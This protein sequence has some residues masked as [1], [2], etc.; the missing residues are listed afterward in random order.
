MLRANRRFLIA[1]VSLWVL[2]QCLVVTAFHPQEV[3]ID[4]SHMDTLPHLA[5]P[6]NI[7]P[8]TVFRGVMDIFVT[9]PETSVTFQLPEPDTYWVRVKA[10]FLRSNQTLE[11]ALNDTPLVPMVSTQAKRAQKFVW[12]VPPSAIRPGDNR[13]TFNNP[14][15]LPVAIEKLDCKNIRSRAEFLPIYIGYDTSR[16]GRRWGHIRWTGVW[17]LAL[18]IVA[19]KLLDQG[20]VAL[21]QRLLRVK[22]SRVVQA[23]R[24]ILLIPPLV[25]FVALLVA[26]WVTPYVIAL[27]PVAAAAL[28][29]A[30]FSTALL[31]ALA[32]VLL[33][34]S[35]LW[36]WRLTVVQQAIA[37][38]MRPEDIPL[39][40]SAKIR[41]AVRVV[42]LV[43]PRLVRGT[44]IAM[45]RATR[46]PTAWYAAF[47]IG[48]GLAGLLLMLQGLY[49]TF[50]LRSAA[51]IVDAHGGYPVLRR[52]AEWC[53]DLG[54]LS[55]LGLLVSAVRTPEPSHE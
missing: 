31:F 23:L 50:A 14:Q 26:S 33:L 44:M 17:W 3:S 22:A 39:R 6:W 7:V 13:I 18:L 35:V 43:M 20:I 11:L 25:P 19:L 24:W 29:G 46:A 40:L 5:G 1:A 42:V 2:C 47:A 54:F 4:L 8:S 48:L 52:M 36:V 34:R 30:T 15:A 45:D 41:I 37:L 38:A 9:A 32:I 55:L 49:Y 28:W 16:L 27:K 12:V 51:A 10:R 53:G 21:W